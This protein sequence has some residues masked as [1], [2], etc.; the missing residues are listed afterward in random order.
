MGGRTTVGLS[1]HARHA[2]TGRSR[3]LPH[4]P[5]TWPA[6]ALSR[7]SFH[8]LPPL[9]PPSPPPQT[10]VSGVPPLSRC[11]MDITTGELPCTAPRTCGPLVTRM[12]SVHTPL[13][14]AFLLL[15]FS[16]LPPFSSS[17]PLFPFLSSTPLRLS[18]PVPSSSPPSPP[19]STSPFLPSPYSL[20]VLSIPRRVC[21]LSFL[22]CATS[23]GRFAPAPSPP[24]PPPDRSACGRCRAL[25]LDVPRAPLPRPPAPRSCWPTREHSPPP[26]P[27]HGLM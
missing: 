10:A 5:A 24:S 6:A 7:A 4:H 8:L 1:H 23:A 18:P 22:L 27:D 11:R 2:V 17:L 19:F 25:Q 13:L 15:L 12:G 14:S 20:P 9:P 26:P 21:D 3:I 16:L